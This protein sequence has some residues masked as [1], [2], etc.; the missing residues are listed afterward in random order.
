MRPVNKDTQQQAEKDKQKG[1]R[2]KLR[3]Y[4]WKQLI[5]S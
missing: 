3:F 4:F 2:A 1:Q 5:S